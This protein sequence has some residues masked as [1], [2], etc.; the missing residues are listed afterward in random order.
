MRVSERASFLSDDTATVTFNPPLVIKA[1]S[2]QTLKVVAEQRSS[3][4]VIN[5]V[6]IVSA[7]SISTTGGKVSGVFPI[8][9]NSM[10]AA[11]YDVASLDITYQGAAS[12]YKV[13]DKNVE[14]AR[15]SVLNESSDK[16]VKVQSF[17][18][19]NSEDGDI[20]EDLENIALYE[21]G[22]K[23][24]SDAIINGRDVTFKLTDYI[25]KA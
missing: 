15:V 9:G 2:T 21:G 24:S 25:I 3:T 18:F 1:G 10:T 19:R 12:E 13:G 6:S 7:D 5:R 8:T 23:V 16:D 11:N 4:N 22:V 17:K 20:G 14:F